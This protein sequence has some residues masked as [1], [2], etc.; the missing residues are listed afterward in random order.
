MSG[1][2]TVAEEEDN[3]EH[4]EGDRAKNYEEYV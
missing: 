2:L 1:G 4:S 3:A